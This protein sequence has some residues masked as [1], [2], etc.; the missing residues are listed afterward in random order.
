MVYLM[1]LC[2]CRFAFALALCGVRYLYGVP[3]ALVRLPL[4]FC[5]RLCG[6]RYLDGV[7]YALVCRFAFAVLRCSFLWREVPGW[8]TLCPCVPLCFCGFA[9]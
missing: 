3:Y 4:C 8:C 5:A 2:A 1:P 9:L 7:P 6:V